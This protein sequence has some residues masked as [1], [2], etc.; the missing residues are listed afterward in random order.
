[1]RNPRRAAGLFVALFLILVVPRAFAECAASI[2]LAESVDEDGDPILVITAKGGGHNLCL[3]KFSAYVDDA[4]I[5]QTPNCNPNDPLCS[6][7]PCRGS[8]CSYDFKYNLG[9]KRTG[10]YTAKIIATCGRQFQDTQ[11]CV[12]DTPGSASDTFAVN[13]TPEIVDFS[14]GAFDP[15][16]N[17]TPV[18]IQYNFP[19]VMSSNQ[20]Q[21]KL[22]R[23][24]T[25]GIIKIWTDVPEQAG[26][27]TWD[28]TGCGEIT[29][30]A[31]ACSHFTDQAFTDSAITQ[32]PDDACKRDRDECAMPGRP[33]NFGSGDVSLTLPLFNIP[34]SPRGL[35]FDM[36]YHSARPAYPTIAREVA[37]GW[38]HSFNPTLRLIRVTGSN[39]RVRET[40]AYGLDEMGRERFY[41]DENELGVWKPVRPA[42]VHDELTR[43]GAELRLRDVNGTVRA[44]DAATGRWL[45]TADRWNNRVSATYDAAGNLTAVTDSV[46]RVITIVASGSRIAQMTLP[47]GAVWRFSYDGNGQLI[48]IHDPLHSGTTAW[49]TFAYQNDSSNVPRLLTAMRDEAGALLEGHTYDGSGRGITS[50]LEA[51][52]E[53]VTLAYDTPSAGKTQVT[54]KIDDAKTQLSIFTVGFIGGRY[55]PTRIEGGCGTCGIISDTEDREYDA[56]GHLIRRVTGDGTVTLQSFNAQGRVTSRTEA[57]GTSAERTVQYEYGFSTWPAFA[58][59]ITEP[60]TFGSRVTTKS[61]SA[62]E[63]ALTTSV[64]GKLSA[65]GADVTLSSVT[66]FDSRH[67]PIS[68][69][70]PRT[71]L[72]DVSVT[73]Y[74]PADAADVALRGRPSS[75]T[76]AVGNSVSYTAYDLYGTAI[77]SRDA[78]DVQM[79][80]LTD[81][82]GRSIRSTSHAVPGNPGESADYVT[83]RTFDGRDRLTEVTSPAGNRIRYTYE[84]GTNLL[85]DTIVLDASGNERERRHVTRNIIGSVTREE[86]QSCASPA[87]VCASW[88]TMRTESY[89]YDGQNRRTEIVNADGT[90]RLFTY[91]A[92]GRVKTEQDENHT[93]PNTTYG[94]DPL[95]RM[96]TITRKLGAGSAVTRYEYDDDGKVLSLTDP[97]GNITRFGYDDFGRRILTDSPVTGISTQS[98]DAAGNVI[99]STLANGVASAMT[100]DAAGRL[101]TQSAT[102]SG[103]VAETITWTYDGGAAF[104]RGRLTSMHDPSGTTLWTYDRRGL[105]TGEQKTIGTAAYSTGYGYDANGNRNRITYPSGRIVNYTFDYADRPYSAASGSTSIVNSASYL[106]F[107]PVREIAFGNGTTQTMAYD[108]RYQISQNRLNGPSGTLADYTYGHDSAGN[109]SRIHDATDAS[110]NRDFQYDDLHR[111]VG[112]N[113]GS[114]LWG[115]GTYDYDAMGNIRSLS[116]GT[117]RTATFSYQGTT[118]K[119]AAVTENGTTRSVAYD[120]AGNEVTVGS[121]AFDYSARN[122]LSQADG[123]S[124]L[125]D[126]RGLRTT[127]GARTP[128]QSIAFDQPTVTGGASPVLTVS[129]SAPAPAGGLTLSLSSDHPAVVPPTTMLVPE[130]STSATVSVATSGV[131]QQV[132]ATISAIAGADRR[133]ATLAIQPPVPLSLTVDP[134]VVTGGTSVT[135]TLTMSGPAPAQGFSVTP[136]STNPAAIVP[137]QVVVPSGAS[138]ALF[139]V[140]TSGVAVATPVTIRA[141]TTA[142]A[143]A[144]LTIQPALPANLTLNPSSVIGGNAA[145]ATLTLNGKAEP[146]GAVASLASNSATVI[147]PATVTIPAGATSAAFTVVTTQVSALAIRDRLRVASWTNAER[148]PLGRTVGTERA[149]AQS[150]QSRRRQSVDRYC[151]PCERSSH[152]RRRCG[153]DERQHQRVCSADR[154]CAGRIQHGDVQ[155]ATTQVST[156][157][158]AHITANL[159]SVVRT[160]DLMIETP[161]NTPPSASFFFNCLGLACTFD[162]SATTDAQGQPL[163]Y[164]WLV[165]NTSIGSTTVLNH[166]FAAPGSYDVTLQVTDNL[167]AAAPPLVR[168]VSVTSEP[169]IALWHWN[170]GK[171]CR[172]YDSRWNGGAKIQ[173]NATIQVPMIAGS[174]CP[175]PAGMRA[176]LLNVVA[177]GPTAVGNVKV[178]GTG[179][180]PGTAALNFTPSWDPRASNVTVSIPNTPSRA[181]SFK[182]T[183]FASSGPAE[184]HVLIDV[185]GFYGDA[186]APASSCGQG[187]WCGPLAFRP[188]PQCRLLDTRTAG[189]RLEPGITRN[190]SV[191][192]DISPNLHSAMALSM[193][194]TA[195]P[196]GNGNLLV[197]DSAFASG[198]VQSV[199][200]LNYRLG[201]NQPNGTITRVS[202]RTDNAHDLAIQARVSATDAVIDVNGVFASPA[203]MPDGLAFYPVAPCRALDTRRPEYGHAGRVVSTVPSFVQ[204]AGNCGIPRGARAV[205]VYSTAVATPAIGN[206][207]V[208]PSN[209]LTTPPTSV[210]NFLAGDTASG[211]ATIIELGTATKDLTLLATTFGSDP[212][213]PLDVVLDVYGYFAPSPVPGGQDANDGS[214]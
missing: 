100:W 125:Y 21:I 9:C 147:V 157:L 111:L 210:V 54:H 12:N 78:N 198:D 141:G 45:S 135:A 189:P 151:A 69:D 109:I 39:G 62:G 81:A 107:G 159:N 13:S 46:G 182:P 83:F 103:A 150:D 209:A 76:D 55:R 162:A 89:V 93:S 102:R 65:G 58:T 142:P 206:L 105:I 194:V 90:R 127:A 48:S 191:T 29:A 31:Y 138:T 79:T 52:R 8:N 16:T 171:P 30:T 84:S 57:A 59:R 71:D 106:P 88:T 117:A 170:S 10:T 37:P 32:L 64:T 110:Y 130:G 115:S 120:A 134:T 192:C 24:D 4:W 50:F 213:A 74:H 161:N 184:T 205:L 22:T 98:H 174:P 176:A 19:N 82:R 2:K 126:G 43:A 156:R 95:G 118:P 185:M 202:S 77:G 200:T 28:V 139:T 131:A 38:T 96:A 61:W 197:Y 211:N 27:L 56:A 113:T 41:E 196:A 104:G 68:V 167:G 36:A 80:A 148:K 122:K 168:R 72:A 181:I 5:G 179:P 204:I 154:T 60:A 143:E 199:S 20:R 87:P 160:A 116:L 187:D 140:T 40:K 214:R 183:V 85:L 178:W 155:R 137:A 33:V 6:Y 121:S 173:S 86:L 163:T 25:G 66:T 47:D 119:L 92:M 44:F 73:T 14:A 133:I 63:T 7:P 145:I 123:Y 15:S 180:E 207:K 195:I 53:L 208:Y 26:E 186:T 152:G 49:R 146:G 164:S 112:A 124:Y 203:L 3:T 136:S 149:H 91:D 67:R 128:L 97:N 94:Y 23:T 165:D 70:G 190:L 35:S 177:L 175:I 212:L 188:I 99:Q 114:S 153:S 17:K 193:N 129:L 101:R 172:I 169:P 201:R 18:T 42:D 11:N 51:N 144:S 75:V 34:Q 158:T 108:S 132:V 166:T 1:M